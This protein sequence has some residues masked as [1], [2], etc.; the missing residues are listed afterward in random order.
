MGDLG[1]GVNLGAADSYSPPSIS[2]RSTDKAG[3]ILAM[4]FDKQ[5][6]E[7][8]LGYDVALDL[9]KQFVEPLA[10]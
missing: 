8:I 10:S 2:T 9:D 4:D 5:F 1:Y 7:P 6:V 3:Q